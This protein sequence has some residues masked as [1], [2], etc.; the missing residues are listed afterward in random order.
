MVDKI[1]LRFMKNKPTLDDLVKPELDSDSDLIFRIALKE[2]A[3]DQERLLKKAS[4][5]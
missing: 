2:S 4:R 3:K 1:R 5:L